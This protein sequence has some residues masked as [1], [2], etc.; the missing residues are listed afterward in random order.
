MKLAVYGVLDKQSDTYISVACYA[1][2][3]IAARVCVAQ[4]AF[5]DN[6]VFS[7]R[8]GDYVLYRLTDP[9]EVDKI[10]LEPQQF[11]AYRSLIGVVKDL[12]AGFDRDDGNIFSD[13]SVEAGR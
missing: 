9:I 13:D 7:K 8:L 12:K 6:P 3:A 10:A 2:D 11:L 1:T 4:I 5:N